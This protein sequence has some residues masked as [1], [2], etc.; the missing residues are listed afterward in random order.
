MPY[1]LCFWII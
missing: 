1:H